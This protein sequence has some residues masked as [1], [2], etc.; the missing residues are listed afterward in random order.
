M[1]SLAK[2]PPGTAMRNHLAILLASAF[3]TAPATA[4]HHHSGQGQPALSPY[5]GTQARSVKA[6]SEQQL[7]DLRAGRGMGMALAAELN[8]YPGPVHV[9][10]LAG[11]L[12]LT[13]EQRD[14]VRA[15]R[16]A[17]MAEA[18]PLGERLIAEEAAL[19]REFASRTVTP[20]SLDA[21]TVAFG[22]SQAE[23]RAAHLRYHLTTVEVL[24]PEQVRRYGELRGYGSGS[25]RH[26]EGADGGG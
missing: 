10:E 6:L 25:V 19:D 18:V 7:A 26:Q 1:V 4:Q 17:M 2:P 5:A 3:A 13:P 11:A 22:R 12:E 16:E 9:L 23:L 24:T 15:L 14:R 20:A 21:A 8:G